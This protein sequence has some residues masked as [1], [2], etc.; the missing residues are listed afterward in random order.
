MDL[1]K[2]H[3]VGRFLELCY[4][5][6][7]KV[8]LKHK[9]DNGWEG[10]SWN[11]FGTLSSK[12]ALQLIENGISVQDKVAIFSNNTPYW[13][14]TD[15][16]IMQS[17]AI[18]VPIHSTESEN[19]IIHI[20]N[21][22]E[23]KIVFVD[24]QQQYDK[25]IS[26]YKKCPN[27][28][29]IVVFSNTIALKE[30]TPSVHWDSFLKAP[31]SESVNKELQLRLSERNIDDLFTLI[32]TSG[33]TGIPKGVMLSYKNLAFQLYSH[34]QFI[35]IH[36]D[37]VSLAFL[38]L[39]HI[40]E[41]AWTAYVLHSGAVNCYLDD[42]QK[43][44]ET[45]LDL[46]PTL[47]CVVPRFFE[48]AYAQIYEKASKASLIKRIIFSLA[49][50]LGKRKVKRN[51]KG[52][53][54]HWLDKK[55]FPLAERL[56]FSKLRHIFGGNLRCVPCG[57]AK[58]DPSIGLF[59]HAIGIDVKL[60]Y[61]LTETTATVSFW[62]GKDFN[63]QSVGTVL[64]G[65]EVKIGAND[66]ILLKGDCVMKGYY[67]LP[68]QTKEAFTD[69]GFF[70]TGDAG[71]VD[72]RGNILIT[73]RIKELMKTSNGKYISPQNIERKVGKDNLI[74]QIMVIAD[75]RKFVSA[76]IVPNYEA[77]N[78]FIKEMK[79]QYKQHKDIINIKEIQD[80]F[81]KRIQKFQKSLPEYEKIKKFTLLSN[82]F[83]IKNNEI[84][85]TLKLKR[86]EIYQRYR[87]EIEAM[88]S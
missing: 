50:R 37:D 4:L 67:K 49:I 54:T 19:N 33:T 56:I 79:I 11:T 84:T 86:K 15:V 44:R 7:D 46:Q 3:F 48:K 25:I 53:D 14:I 8:A 34:Q 2:Y 71:K 69:D 1:S 64:P 38:P 73:D 77:L 32:Y 80:L 51:L 74:E 16:G 78:D 66:E 6:Q 65:I 60:G 61:G 70:R 88:Y 43:I 59:F 57:G 29:Q 45:L 9:T 58:L 41:R 75:G 42:T 24:G 13:T 55:L 22:S 26:S 81:Y 62:Q 63:I 72:A 21:N 30:G 82:P 31:L 23:A 35:K 17:R 12:V 47:M 20:L 5:H 28:K 87:K 10:I 68:E 18:C 85:P 52:K 76:L 83:S 27:L 40:F 36:P 39:S